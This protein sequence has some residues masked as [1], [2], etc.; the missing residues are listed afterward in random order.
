VQSQRKQTNKQ[1]QQVPC[2]TSILV[3][4]SFLGGRQHTNE[5]HAAAAAAAHS[6]LANFFIF[7]QQSSCYCTSRS[8][9]DALIHASIKVQCLYPANTQD[10]YMRPAVIFFRPTT[11]PRKSPSSRCFATFRRGVGARLYHTH[12]QEQTLSPPCKHP[13]A[14]VTAAAA[15]N[16]VRH[17]HRLGQRN[18]IASTP[19]NQ[20]VTLAASHAFEAGRGWTP[21]H[22]SC[23]GCFQA[24]RNG[25]KLFGMR[26]GGL[27][28][29]TH[30]L[31]RLQ[32]ISRSKAGCNTHCS[33]KE[34]HSSCCCHHRPPRT[35]PGRLRSRRGQ[36]HSYSWMQ[37]FQARSD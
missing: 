15:A 4:P 9:P 33:D 25:F 17:R 27:T 23:P 20:G 10:L 6:S 12:T 18:P 19:Q 31:G 2:Q 14:L 35:S 16:I 34:C 36:S 1:W 3:V 11:P 26:G 5:H 22:R 13:A 29:H 24:T 28:P 21:R 30:Q 32:G 8:C 37:P 7:F